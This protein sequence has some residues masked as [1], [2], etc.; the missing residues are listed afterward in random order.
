[1]VF[2]HLNAQQLGTKETPPIT[3]EGFSYPSFDDGSRYAE[4]E[5]TMPL[6][7]K[8]EANIFGYHYRNLIAERFRI[9]IQVKRYLGNKVYT[10]GGYELEWDLRNKGK[11]VPNPRPLQSIYYGM[12]YDVKPGLSLE[13]TMQHLI[14]EPEFLPLGSLGGNTFLK[15][16]TKYKF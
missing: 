3:I 9:P 6:S 10:V 5:I 4:F 12:G 11:G 2:Y 13:A 1:M 16:G 8:T 15:V 14:V 7:E